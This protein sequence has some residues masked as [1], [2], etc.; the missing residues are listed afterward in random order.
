[1]YATLLFA[2]FFCSS[3]T[4]VCEQNPLRFIPQTRNP[5]VAFA[6]AILAGI[7]GD[8]LETRVFISTLCQE[9]CVLK[10]THLTY[11][12]ATSHF[13]SSRGMSCITSL[14]AEPR[15]YSLKNVLI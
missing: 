7:R 5:Y 11:P 13:A 15:R 10:A 2:I 9:N 4:L 1:M 8:Y 3:G 14:V 12:S 6:D